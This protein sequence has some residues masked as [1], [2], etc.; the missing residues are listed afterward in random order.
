MSP[1]VVCRP[2]HLV[3][4]QYELGWAHEADVRA[5]PCACPVQGWRWVAAQYLW[6]ECQTFR[7]NVC[8]DTLNE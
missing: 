7:S 8:D 5:T 3:T 2:A 4:C 1:R 6:K